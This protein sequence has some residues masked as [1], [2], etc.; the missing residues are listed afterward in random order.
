MAA[1]EEK[2]ANDTRVEQ[3]LGIGNKMIL[4][5]V[6]HRRSIYKWKKVDAVV[7]PTWH[8]N[9]CVGADAADPCKGENDYEVRQNISVADAI[10]WASGLPF[11]VTIYLWDA[12]AAMEP[13]S[14]KA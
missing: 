7:E 10:A 1:R 9:K 14:S 6:D 12:G 3:S 4:N 13:V 5:F 11:D 2:I 8:D